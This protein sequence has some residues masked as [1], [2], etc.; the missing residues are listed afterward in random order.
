MVVRPVNEWDYVIVGGGSAGCV[1]ANRLSA[2]PDVRVLLLE[3]GGWDRH[4]LIRIPA[5]I[6]KL[7]ARFDWGYPATPD[8]SRNGMIEQWAGGKVLGGGSSVNMMLWVRGERSDYDGWRD[9]GC[10]GWGFDDVLPYFKRAETFADGGDSY[11]GSDGPIGVSRSSIKLE[12]LDDFLEAAHSSGHPVNPDYNG[13]AQRGVSLAQASQRRGFRSSTARGYLAPV[14]RRPNL[15]IKTRTVVTRVLFEGNRAVGVQYQD[16]RGSGQA[17][18]R[19]EVV[20][21]AGALAT[22]KL[23]MLSGIGSAGQL[24]SHG[25][26]VVVDAPHVGQNLQDHAYGMLM[27]RTRAGTLAEE[28]TPLRAV[29]HFV[30]F[31]LH[32]RGALTQGG[33]AAI[34]FDQIDGDYATETEIIF[35]PVGLSFANPDAVHDIHDLAIVPHGLT[36]YPSHVHPTSRG[37][38]RLASADPAAGPMIEHEM[39]G[40][41]EDLDNLVRVC[42]QA[43]DIM[44]TPA[45]K[46]K[47]TAE[48]IPGEQ[49]QTDREWAEF[50]KANAFRPYHPVGTCRMGSD[51]RS[52]VDPQLRVRGAEGLRVVDASV[53]PTITSGNTNAPTIMLAER[54]VDLMLNN[55]LDPASTPGL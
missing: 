2:N 54:G 49:V 12:V 29:R 37:R 32:G 14:R 45:M 5:G 41:T 22:P 6:A 47:V 23:L 7:P 50:L 48:E 42:R 21:S 9:Q 19:A 46:A 3:A 51:D 18:V 39:F 55:P 36:L 34:V 35:I 38:L 31:V 20:L 13:Q 10:P 24:R 30:D 44:A 11:R 17:R 52:V 25:I 43:R 1:L 8:A 53:F 26:D 16:R 15:T 4:P 33:A 40:C 28:T 27:Y